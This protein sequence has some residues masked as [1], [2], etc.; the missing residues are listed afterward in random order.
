MKVQE[1]CILTLLGNL[2]ELITKYQK[3]NELLR[4]IDKLEVVLYQEEELDYFK[5]SNENSFIKEEDEGD[6]IKSIMELQNPLVTGQ[7]NSF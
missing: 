5:E 1:L 2:T 3:D 4:E 6:T 7:K